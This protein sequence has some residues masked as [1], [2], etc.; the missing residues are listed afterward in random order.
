MSA[1]CW[2]PSLPRP[3]KYICHASTA[4][5]CCC[6]CC[7]FRCQCLSARTGMCAQRTQQRRQQT[8]TRTHGA[9]IKYTHTH[10]Q[11]KASVPAAIAP[12][13]R[14]APRLPFPTQTNKAP[15]TLTESAHTRGG[16]GAALH[17]PQTHES[18]GAHTICCG[19]LCAQSAAAFD[20]AASILP[21]VQRNKET[22]HSLTLAMAMADAPCEQ[23]AHSCQSHSRPNR[24]S[25]A[26]PARAGGSTTGVS[27]SAAGQTAALSCRVHAHA[28]SLLLFERPHTRACCRG[29]HQSC[30]LCRLR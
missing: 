22:R 6:R 3:M 24:H 9:E 25:P 7:C 23:A 21:A 4:P 14:K 13:L 18:S 30:W 2:Q 29:K 8:H 27:V 1:S 28:Y 19:A 10:T 20:A 11:H 5:C 26:A 15:V 16:G 12:G 17:A